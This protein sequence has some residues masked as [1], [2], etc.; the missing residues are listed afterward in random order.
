MKNSP[1]HFHEARFISKSINK[2]RN[3]PLWVQMWSPSTSQTLSLIP[4]EK[5]HLCNRWEHTGESVAMD[6][7]AGHG[8]SN[9]ETGTVET[10][11]VENHLCA[12]RRFCVW[13]PR[14]CRKTGLGGGHL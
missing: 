7:A 11:Q 3:L 10:A 1:I 5:S 12:N 8:V 13:I 4:Q 14:I 2:S 6:D 9:R